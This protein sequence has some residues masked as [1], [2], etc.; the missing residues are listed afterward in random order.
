MARYITLTEQGLNDPIH[1]DAEKIVSVEPSATG[2]SLIR[3]YNVAR[4]VMETPDKVLELLQDEPTVAEP[5][6]AEQK[7]DRARAHYAPLGVANAQVLQV[8]VPADSSVQNLIDTLDTH[9][10]RTGIPADEFTLIQ[11][12]TTSGGV[13]LTFAAGVS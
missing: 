9:D 12:E 3:I 2:G 4:T 8:L 7:V 10:R 13:M 11:A 5:V 1:I 6:V